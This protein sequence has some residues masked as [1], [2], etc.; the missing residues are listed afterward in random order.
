MK[1]EKHL[2]H[3]SIE[4][5]ET[6]DFNNEY[7]KRLLEVIQE[8][9]VIFSNS[10][11]RYIKNIAAAGSN[12]ITSESKRLGVSQDIEEKLYGHIK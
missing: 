3:G 12:A 8:L 11:N 6:I 1:F 2:K 10:R 7:S 5:S 4:K 9:D